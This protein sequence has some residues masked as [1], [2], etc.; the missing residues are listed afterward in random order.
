MYQPGQELE[1]LISRR[2]RLKQLTICLGRKPSHN[3]QLE[4][5]PAATGDAK[6][7]LAKWLQRPST[8]ILPQRRKVTEV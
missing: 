2:G 4:I 3:W 6:A 8:E 5:D 1:L 7:N